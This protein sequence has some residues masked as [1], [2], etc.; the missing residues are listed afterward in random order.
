MNWCVVEGWWRFTGSAGWRW[1][2][3]S[4]GWLWFSLFLYY[5]IIERNVL[6]LLVEFMY[7][8]QRHFREFG[9]EFHERLEF[10]CFI[11]D[12]R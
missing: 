9:A 1:F 7:L 12:S 8:R 10:G 3:E 2:A 4:A 6:V 5:L 11:C